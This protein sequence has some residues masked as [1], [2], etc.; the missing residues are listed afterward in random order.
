MRAAALA[1]LLAVAASFVVVGVALLSV[2]AAWVVAGT[3]LAGWSVLLFAEVG[4]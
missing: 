1:S 4:G 3:L 2:P